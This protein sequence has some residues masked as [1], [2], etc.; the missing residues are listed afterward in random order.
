[1]TFIIATNNA[2]KLLEL[3]R[4][5]NPLGIRTL[6]AN[7]AGVS[8]GEVEETGETFEENARLKARAALD[9]TGMPALADD[10]GLM[11]DAL[12]G[13][14]GVYSARYGGEGA[15]D[16]QKNEKLLK[17]MENVPKGKRTARFVSAICCLFPDGREIM[18]RGE[19]E[20]SIA[21]APRGEGGFGYDPVFLVGERSYAQLTPEEKDAVSHRGQALRKLSEELKKVLQGQE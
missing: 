1:M 18:V 3:S 13:E 8:L 16:A 15:T 6:S 21:Y 2:K 19:C 9:K 14:P 17:N 5:L 7:E 11:V 4:I 20:G 12:N 10:S